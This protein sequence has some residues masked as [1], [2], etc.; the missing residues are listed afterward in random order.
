MKDKIM[1]WL[2]V[3]LYRMADWTAVYS[4]MMRMAGCM[5]YCTLGC[6]LV[7]RKTAD[8]MAAWFNGRSTGLQFTV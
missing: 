5:V 4:L 3:W 7:K 2:T 8:R 6:T 1:D